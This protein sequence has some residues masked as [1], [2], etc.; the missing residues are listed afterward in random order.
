MNSTVKLWTAVE[1]EK[2]EE[3]LDMFE[4]QQGFREKRSTRDATFI[5]RQ[6]VEKSIEYNKLAYICFVN[7]RN[8]FDRVQHDIL[9]LIKA[10]QIEDKVINLV[11]VIEWKLLRSILCGKLI[12]QY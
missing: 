1:K 9:K 11:K 5:I 12:T 8:S 7:Q 3:R 4:E 6:I 10:K 2:L